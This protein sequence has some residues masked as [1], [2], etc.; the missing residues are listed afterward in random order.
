MKRLKNIVIKDEI[1]IKDKDG[2]EIAIDKNEMVSNLKENHAH[3]SKTKWDS[4]LGSFLVSEG[5]ELIA[6]DFSSEEFTTMCNLL[7]RATSESLWR[8]YRW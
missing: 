6:Q 3:L 1:K 7:E 8:Y 4:S 2:V 5:I